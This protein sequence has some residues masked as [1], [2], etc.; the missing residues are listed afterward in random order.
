MQTAENSSSTP[1]S[2]VTLLL[3]VQALRALLQQQPH[4]IFAA[5]V[6][7]RANGRAHADSDWDIA[8]QWDHGLDLWS[9]L[10]NTETLRRELAITLQVPESSVDLIDLRRA[11]LTMRA[12]VA[13]EGLILHGENTLAWPQFLTRTWR[14]LEDFYWERQHAA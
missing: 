4:L 9:L 14:E 8:L 1:H 7:S 12:S 3:G 11:N 10:A 6:G 5:L 2:P 13:E